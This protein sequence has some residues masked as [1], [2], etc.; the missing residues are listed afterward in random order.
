M[1]IKEK[2]EYLLKLEKKRKKLDSNR[3]LSVADEIEVEVLDDCPLIIEI[4]C[5]D[6]DYAYNDINVKR[7]IK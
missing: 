7:S 4:L 5:S 3:T 2:I 6:E 1:D